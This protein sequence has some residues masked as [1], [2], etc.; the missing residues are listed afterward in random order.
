[1]RIPEV[2]EPHRFRG[3]YLV[4]HE[5]W[6][7]LGYTADEVAMLLESERYRQ[8]RI[9]R[10]HNALPDGRM[11]LVGVSPDRFQLE[12]G[13]FFYSDNAEQASCDYDELVA[14]AARTL[15]P[16]RAYVQLADRGEAVDF[17]RYVIALVFPAEAEADIGSWLSQI[18][19]EGGAIAEG[20]ISYVTNYLE[21]TKTILQRQQFWNTP[22]VPSRSRE[23][24]LSSVSVP[25]QRWA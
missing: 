7:A 12:S 19:Y 14:Q 22:A 6:S 21:E 11:E 17:G 23:E 2:A 5:D 9:Y 4:Q 18:G 15:P 1:M 24:V 25:V 3:L 8:A 20:G 13:M 10:V 16:V